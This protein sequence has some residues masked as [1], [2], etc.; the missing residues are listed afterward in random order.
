MKSLLIIVPLLLLVALLGSF[1]WVRAAPIDVE[2]LHRDPAETG[3]PGNA[4]VR[5]LPPEAPVWPIPPAEAMAALDRAIRAEGRVEMIAGSVEEGFATYVIR[6]KFWGFPD[7]VNLK[8]I[9]EGAGST[10]ALRARSIRAEYDWGVNRARAARWF[11][12]I[13][14]GA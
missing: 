7:V 10:V 3:D 13:A 5:V 11:E 14:G 8:V 6:T 4:G 9:A 2:R 12:S 1:L